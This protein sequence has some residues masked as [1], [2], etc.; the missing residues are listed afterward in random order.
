MQARGF[1]GVDDFFVS[2]VCFA[3]A[4]VF[5]DGGVEEVWFLRDPGDGIQK[6]ER[7]EGRIAP[8]VGWMKPSSN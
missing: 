8:C 6:A 1:G 7:S 3:E 5:G 4:D 2:C